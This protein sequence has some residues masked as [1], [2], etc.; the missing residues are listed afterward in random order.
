VAGKFPAEAAQ[1]FIEPFQR[2][3]SCATPSVVS[4][5]GGYHRSDRPLS[6]L[7][8]RGA[9]QRLRGV[10]IAIRVALYY[11]IIESSDDPRGPWKATT[12]GYQYAL[13]DLEEDEILAYHWHPDAALGQGA[14][15]GRQEL[16]TA[17]LP[18]SRV[19]LSNS[20]G[21]ALVTSKLSRCGTTTRLFSPRPS[22]PLTDKH[23]PMSPEHA[24]TLLPLTQ[25]TWLRG[26]APGFPVNVRAANP[27]PAHP[28]L[29]EPAHPGRVPGLQG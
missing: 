18:T 8:G 24:T 20:C 14:A 16:Q 22:S 15:V 4:A 10:P 3:V 6:L 26:A 2:S 9:P 29:P 13:E 1:S 17:H 23:R 28:D 27:V 5:R 7:L 12:T 11:R 21:C 25:P 19:P